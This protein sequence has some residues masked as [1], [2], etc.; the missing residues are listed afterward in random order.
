MTDFQQGF[1]FGIAFMLALACVVAVLI[2]GRG[3]E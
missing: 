2:A 1:L 3:R